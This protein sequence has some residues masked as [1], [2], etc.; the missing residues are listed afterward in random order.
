LRA[1][2]QRLGISERVTVVGFRTDLAD[3]LR[4]FDLQ[5]HSS[6]KE[7]LPIAVCSGMA[8]GRPLISTDIDGVAEVVHHGRS[9]LLVPPGDVDAFVASMTELLCDR[10][11][12][13]T[14]GANARCQMRDTFRLETV[15]KS[16]EQVYQTVYAESQAGV[17]RR[18]AGAA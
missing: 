5:V 6:F 10:E 3:I 9:G 15:V 12:A 16:L 17:M 1:R 4:I 2:C 8:A 18:A 13:A 11:R 14:L 7:G